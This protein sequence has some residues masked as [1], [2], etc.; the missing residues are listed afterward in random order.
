MWNPLTNWS[1]LQGHAEATLRTD[2]GIPLSTDTLNTKRQ[3]EAAV[4]GPG[5]QTRLGT[6]AVLR[7]PERE[8]C[9]PGLWCWEYALLA[10]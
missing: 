8:P 5:S 7:A 2:Y 9:A 10:F 1:G 4:T 6:E 3:P